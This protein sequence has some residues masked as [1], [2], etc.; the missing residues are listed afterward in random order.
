[1]A[2]LYSELAN[3]LALSIENGLLRP[4][5]KLPGV[6]SA[7]RNEGVSPS[8]VVAAYRHLETE[9]YIEA[10]ARS[11]FYVRPRLQTILE[12]PETSKP[13]TKPK[14]VSGQALVLRLIQN[15]NTPNIVQLGANIPDQSFLPTRA[16]ARSLSAVAKGHSGAV[17]AYEIPPGLLE[18]RQQIA[19]RMAQI[20]CI[21]DPQD[22]VV[23]SGCQEAV[24][25]SLKS[26]TKPGDIV[27][28]ESPTYYGLLQAIDALGLKALE[29]PTNPAEGISVDALQLAL[30]QW[31]VKACVVVPNFN[32]PL[33]ALMPQERKAELVSLV[34]QHRGV[35]LIEDDIYGDLNFDGKRPSVLK[36]LETKNNIIHCASYSKTVSAGLRIGWAISNRHA[37]Q[38]AY[39]KYVSNCA[40]S[41][42]GQ[43][44]LAHFLGSGGY[45]RHIRTMNLSLMQNMSRLI[46][47][48][49]QHFPAGTKVSRPTGGMT[50]WVELDK[51]IDTT[52]LSHNA[53]AQGISIAPG[54][55]FSSSGGKYKNCLRLNCGVGWSEQVELAMYALGK[56]AGKI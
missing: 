56:L 1:M 33:G 4:G 27:A 13:L 26:V 30:E 8:T 2:H 14:P 15:I 38:L 39:E 7:S 23:T 16:I 36:S 53:L 25:L 48:V 11:G 43:L 35:T 55:I 50:L 29:I 31:P 54:Q 44:T 24:Y 22:I 28:I 46:D 37:Q 49:G 5:E 21:T 41:S 45:D 32:N 52:A 17:C 34:N 42:V 40:T 19:K 18:L 9:G 47:R 51:K 12:E 20:G 3:H 10:R 6:R